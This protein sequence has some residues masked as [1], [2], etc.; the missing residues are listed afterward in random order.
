LNFFIMY[1][2]PVGFWFYFSWREILHSKIV[3]KKT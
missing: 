2:K 1:I 3:N